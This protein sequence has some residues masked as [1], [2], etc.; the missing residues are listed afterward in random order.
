MWFT[1]AVLVGWVPDY[2]GKGRIIL[3][4]LLAPSV[5]ERQ[6]LNVGILR[7]VMRGFSYLSRWVQV[8]GLCGLIAIGI[9]TAWAGFVHGR[10]A[11]NT[12]LSILVVLCLTMLLIGPHLAAH[13]AAHARMKDRRDQ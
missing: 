10:S 2:K 5:V 6:N 13:V 7:Q 9:A 8:F 1:S 11:M 4:V 12:V 3:V